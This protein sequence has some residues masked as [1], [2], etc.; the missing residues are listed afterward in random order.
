MVGGLLFSQVVTLYV[1][2][3]IYT[4]FDE[5][6]IRFSKGHAV[7]VPAGAMQPGVATASVRA[8]HRPE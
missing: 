5:L 2:P 3:V 8:A 1:T 6:K 4:Y 7:T